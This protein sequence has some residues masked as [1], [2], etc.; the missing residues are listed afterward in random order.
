MKRRTL[1]FTILLC[2]F[3]GIFIFRLKTESTALDSR[4]MDDFDLVHNEDKPSETEIE[5][6][7]N[8]EDEPVE[9]D[10]LAGTT[11]TDDEGNVLIKNTDDI[12]V[13][14]NKN[15]NFLLITSLMI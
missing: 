3:I 5:D 9:E 8:S 1:A 12:L 14:V 13:L 2:V 7:P 6:G 4:Y 15:R 10:L 11:F